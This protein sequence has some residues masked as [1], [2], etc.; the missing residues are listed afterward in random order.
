MTLFVLL[1]KPKKHYKNG[2]NSKKSLDQFSTYNLDQF[3]TYKRP[4]LGP[5]FNSTACIYIYIHT[6]GK[7]CGPFFGLKGGNLVPWRGPDS[8]LWRF[9]LCL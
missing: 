5:V 6:V 4:D 9:G 8:L 1:K 2:G 3:L 7:E